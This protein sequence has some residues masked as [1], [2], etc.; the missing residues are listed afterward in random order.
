MVN[1]QERNPKALIHTRPVLALFMAY[2][3][4]FF[5]MSVFSDLFQL[6]TDFVV[7]SPIGRYLLPFVVAFSIWNAFRQ[8]R[9]RDTVRRSTGSD[10]S[11]GK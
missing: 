9:P 6:L 3:S 11:S 5:V 7:L 4:C 10:P 2:A 1:T 8:V